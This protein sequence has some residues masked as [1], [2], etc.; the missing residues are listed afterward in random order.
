MMMLPFRSRAV[1]GLADR[2][3]DGFVARG[4]RG[5]IAVCHQLMSGERLRGDGATTQR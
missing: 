3:A 4:R 1:E 5:G 2:E